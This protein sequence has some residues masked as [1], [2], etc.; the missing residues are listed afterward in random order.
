VLIGISGLIVRKREPAGGVQYAWGY[1]GPLQLKPIADALVAQCNH[2][3]AAFE[4]FQALIREHEAAISSL[5]ARMLA[6]S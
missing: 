3:Y 2:C 5:N 1:T 4:A 6:G